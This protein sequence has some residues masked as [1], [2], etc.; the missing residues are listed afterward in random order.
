M[1]DEQTRLK[2]GAA[3]AHRRTRRQGSQAAQDGVA[4]DADAAPGSVY[5]EMSFR[6]KASLISM[7]RRLVSDFY[8]NQVFADP[9]VSSRLALAM[10]ELLENAVKYGTDEE[11]TVRLEIIP[12][13]GTGFTR[14]I[15]RTENRASQEHIATL[16][17]CVDRIRG[18]SDASGFYQQLLRDTSDDDAEGS[19]GLGLARICAEAEMSLNH[20]VH[21]DMV[22]VVAEA[23]IALKR[24]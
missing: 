19:S 7:V 23:R 22:S 1:G 20:E 6:P 18:A 10:H 21:E 11:S 12:E 5:I 14:V 13:E 3:A 15:I 17:R 24:T 16:T 9:D 4:T 2:T 8:G